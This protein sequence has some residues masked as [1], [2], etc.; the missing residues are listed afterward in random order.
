M[1]DFG[2]IFNQNMSAIADKEKQS[3][4]EGKKRI[5]ESGIMEIFEYFIQIAS[6]PFEKQTKNERFLTK[7]LVGIARNYFYQR[8]KS[9]LDNPVKK[10]SLREINFKS[11]EIFGISIHVSFEDNYEYKGWYGVSLNTIYAAALNRT[12]INIYRYDDDDKVLE[13]LINEPKESI[14]KKILNFI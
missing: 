4:E 6:L 12:N 13:I 1:D 5:Q 9:S 10:I 7:R 8:R 11:Q 2:K 3:K 14:L